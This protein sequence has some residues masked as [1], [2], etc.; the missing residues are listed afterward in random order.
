MRGKVAV[1]LLYHPDRINYPLKRIG[2][3]GEGKWQRISWDEALD[4]IAN[5]LQS[6]KSEFGP[7]A[8]CLATGAALYYNPG[9]LGY[10]ASQLG[11]PNVMLDGHLC[12][13]RRGSQ[14]ERL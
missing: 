11:T 8:I 10:V 12:F 3:K 14:P 13:C 9:I 7:E 1:E 6:I 5:K 2:Q 4:T